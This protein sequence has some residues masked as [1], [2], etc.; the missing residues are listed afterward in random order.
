MLF[1]VY[2]LMSGTDSPPEEIVVSAGQIE[3]LA[4]GY[5]RTWHRQPT[6]AELKGLIDDWVRDEIATREAMALGLDKDDTVIRRRLR[7][8]LD[9][10]SED[11]ADQAEPT[12]TELSDYLK[13]HPE[14]FRIEPRFT[15]SQVFLDPDRH[16]DQLSRDATRLLAQLRKTG[17][18][19]DILALGDSLLLEQTFRSVST[20]EVAVQF[21]EAF[22]ARL[23]ELPTGEWQG[24]VESGYGMHIVFINERTKAQTP[25]LLEVRDDVRREWQ[26]A[27]RLAS[28]RKFYEDLLKRYTVTIERPESA[29]EPKDPVEEN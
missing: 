24:P 23:A 9:F 13:A 17:G 15:F 27:H 6:D 5:A 29:N 28:N 25:A 7:Q 14:S 22:A 3:H 2:R 12:D 26:N 11:L 1:T 10:V 19:A 21:G 20:R 8:K 16:G 18:Q 4:A